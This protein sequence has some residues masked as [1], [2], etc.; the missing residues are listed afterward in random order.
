MRT[1]EENPL[2]RQRVPSGNISGKNS[3]K[4]SATIPARI[5]ANR[6]TPPT[7]THSRYFNSPNCLPATGRGSNRPQYPAMSPARI[8]AT[9]WQYR[10]QSRHSAIVSVPQFKA[11]HHEHRS[12][13]QGFRQKIG[14]R[15]GNVIS[16]L[17][18][19]T[20]PRPCYHRLPRT[21]QKRIF[22]EKLTNVSLG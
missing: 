14:N 18:S 9:K 5:S 8:P 6:L 20:L 21:S 3:G 22:D 17:P 13:R 2:S 7:G 16:L 10:Q 19:L 1:P 11:F 4:K 15:S 12:H